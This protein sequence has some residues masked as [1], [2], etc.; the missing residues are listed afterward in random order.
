VSAEILRTLPKTNILNSI[1]GGGL[2]FN[3]NHDPAA[4]RFYL[5]R[6]VNGKAQFVS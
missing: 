3:K 4:A 1:L 6:V 2:K 5:F